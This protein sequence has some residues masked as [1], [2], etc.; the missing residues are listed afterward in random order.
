[1]ETTRSLKA[2][3]LFALGLGCAVAIFAV[4]TANAVGGT[5]RVIVGSTINA[6]GEAVPVVTVTA[7]K[8]TTTQK[9]M[10]AVRDVAYKA[11]GERG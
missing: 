9:V 4:D 11:K 10:L 5:T 1:M 7:K 3:L 2:A 8:L 6:A